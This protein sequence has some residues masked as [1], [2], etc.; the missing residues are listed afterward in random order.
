LPVVNLAELDASTTD[1]FPLTVQ[2]VKLTPVRLSGRSSSRDMP[3]RAED[4]ETT[5]T[6]LKAA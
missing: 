3:P 5:E 6:P 4:P 1:P 2:L